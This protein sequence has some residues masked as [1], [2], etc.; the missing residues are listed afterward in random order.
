[1]TNPERWPGSPT[2]A[3]DQEERERLA[4]A[5]LAA[6]T[7]AIRSGT[8]ENI[9]EALSEV[10]YSGMDDVTLDDIARAIYDGRRSHG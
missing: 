9:A 5:A 10:A 7:H 2:A 6:L 1:M 3:A 4:K 8:L